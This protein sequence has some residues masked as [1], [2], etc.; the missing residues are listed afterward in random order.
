MQLQ[1]INC[2]QLSYLSMSNR[3]LALFSRLEY[4]KLLSAASLMTDHTVEQCGDTGA[5]ILFNQVCHPSIHCLICSHAVLGVYLNNPEQR[6]TSQRSPAKQQGKDW[7]TVFLS[8]TLYVLGMR[9]KC[10]PPEQ[11]VILRN[12]YRTMVTFNWVRCYCLRLLWCSPLLWATVNILYNN[13]A[14]HITCETGRF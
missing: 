2:M 7:L 6:N 1:Y 8:T 11:G 4:S 5:G 13:M 3:C 10:E 12:P 9:K 14:G